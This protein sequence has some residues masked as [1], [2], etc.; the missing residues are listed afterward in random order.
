MQQNGKIS[1]K[2]ETWFKTPDISDNIWNNYFDKE[3]EKI[4]IKK[5]LAYEAHQLISEERL[6]GE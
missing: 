2:L 6:H 4:I 3:E 5:N 1:K